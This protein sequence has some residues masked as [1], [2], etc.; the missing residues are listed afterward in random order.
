M[1]KVQFP[2]RDRLV[3]IP[4]ELVQVLPYAVIATLV[5]GFF[6]NWIVAA[7]LLT[8][9]LA[10]TVLF[11]V[12]LPYIPT[13]DFSTK[14][15]ILGFVVM[16]PFIWFNTAAGGSLMMQAG[17]AAVCLLFFPPITAFLALNFTGAT[18]FTSRTGVRKEIFTY[19]RVMAAMFVTGFI[20]ALFLF[21]ARN[22]V[23]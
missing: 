20:I 4:V 18:T 21:L 2:L 12:L 6:L 11:P 16:L 10:G 3:L 5:V 17:Y 19:I 14:G 15:L 8:A 9:A 1:R 13:K 7:Q 23:I 22:T